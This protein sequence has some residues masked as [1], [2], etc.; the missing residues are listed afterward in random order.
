MASWADKLKSPLRSRK[1][2]MALATIVAAYAGSVGLNVGEDVIAAI[3]AVG[4][5]LILGTAHEDHGT[6]SNIANARDGGAN[7]ARPPVQP[8]PTA[9]LDQEAYEAAIHP[10]TPMT[11]VRRPPGS[12]DGG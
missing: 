10:L 12:S 2:V 6:K 4:V 11:P 7:A 8:A 1:V 3:V 9:G 5:A